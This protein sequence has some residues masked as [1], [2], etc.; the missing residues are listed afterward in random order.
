VLSRA[1]DV[2]GDGD[3]E[4]LAGS[5]FIDGIVGGTELREPGEAYLLSLRR[6]AA[7]P[8]DSEEARDFAARFGVTPFT[9]LDPGQPRPGVLAMQGESAFR[10]IGHGVAGAGDLNG[11]GV[12]DLAVGQGTFVLTDCGRCSGVF[13]E[14]VPYTFVFFGEKGL[15]DGRV[16]LLGPEASDVGFLVRG[17]GYRVA[18]GGDVNGDGYADLVTARF[19]GKAYILFGGPGLGEIRFRRGDAD[20]SG[21][22]EI[23]DAIRTLGH[24]FLGTAPLRCL[25]AADID[26]DGKVEITDP[27]RLLDHLFLGGP[28]PLPPFPEPGTDPTTDSLECSDV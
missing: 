17:A 18:G 23:S 21:R 20:L 28:A 22:I 14:G 26:D 15:L 7:P 16:S 12:P 10:R 25:D 27:I 4:L 24:L 3:E 8:P 13:N 5:P 9:V 2:D 6:D 19:G 11:D 1:G